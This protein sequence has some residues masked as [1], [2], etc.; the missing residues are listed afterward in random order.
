[1]VLLVI[2]QY[3]LLLLLSLYARLREQGFFECR[4]RVSRASTGLP[5]QGYA[6]LHEQGFAKCLNRATPVRQVCLRL[7]HHAAVLQY[8]LKSEQG[9]LATPL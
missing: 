7:N 8:W 6:S 1:M 4:S 9:N 3:Y 5:E 2:Y